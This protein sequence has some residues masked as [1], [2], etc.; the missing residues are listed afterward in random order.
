LSKK[1]E[2]TQLKTAQDS[3]EKCAS[4]T[5]LK[6]SLHEFFGFNWSYQKNPSE[7]LINHLEIFILVS[8][9]PKSLN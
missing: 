7:L 1:E 9:S 2:N 5:V 8:N 3:D 6:E 4:N